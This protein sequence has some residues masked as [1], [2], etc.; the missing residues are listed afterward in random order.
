MPG[1][2]PPSL[3]VFL[4]DRTKGITSL[5]SVDATSLGGGNGDSLPLGVSTNGR[6]ALFQSQASNLL[7]SPSDGNNG[8]DI[9]VRDVLNGATMLIS[10]NTNADF[11]NGASRD[12][13]MTPD[14]RYVAFVSE[15]SDLVPG[16]TNRIAD[17]F[18]RDLQAGTTAL[19][20][21]GALSTNAASPVGGSE[22]PEITPDGRYVAFFST[23]TNLVPGVQ[24][25]GEIYLRDRVAGTTLWASAGAGAAAAAVFG[26]SP[27][28]SFNHRSVTMEGISRT[29]QAGLA[30]MRAFCCD[31]IS[32]PVQRIQFLRTPPCLLPLPFSTSTASI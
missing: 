31:T 2:F 30:R 6:Y 17:V 7:P 4:R 28:I 12:A 14:G 22:A 24:G 26:I 20:S 23:A 29:K 16:D 9:F 8:S 10:A 21:I 15:A 3:N 13:V 1:D 11:A 27:V 32:P 18:V 25:I 5:V 19:V